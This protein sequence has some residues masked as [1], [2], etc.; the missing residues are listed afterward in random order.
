MRPPH[1]AGEN[2]LQAIVSHAR[3][4]AS[5]RPPHYAGENDRRRRH[6]LR[7]QGAS[8]RPPHYAGE[9]SG[10]QTPL[11][12]HSPA[13]VCERSRTFRSLGSSSS[14]LSAGL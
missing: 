6:R 1:Y 7:P 3:L 5:M 2:Q 10:C 8:M 11:T 13:P 4:L 14:R 12:A 9:N